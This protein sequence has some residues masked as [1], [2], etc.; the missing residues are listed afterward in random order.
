MN[1]KKRPNILF[2]VIDALRED[3]I[4]SEN[5]TTKT[6]TI[7]KL[8]NNGVYFSQAISTSDVTGTGIGCFFSGVYPFESGITESKIDSTLFTLINILKKNGYNMCG[9]G[10]NFKFFR[11]LS[12]F[13]D[14]SYYYDYQQWREIDTILGK[15]GNDIIDHLESIQKEP[16]F[17]YLH[18]MD[19]HGMGK[20][21]KIPSKFD[22][23]NFGKTKYDRMISCIDFW[24]K[25]LLKQIDLDNTIIIITADHGEYVSS[26]IDDPMGIPNVYKFL[27][28]MKKV[29]PILE[30]IGNQMFRILLKTNAN[31][32]RSI[33][34][35]QFDSKEMRDILTRGN[36]D[37]LFDD[38][39]KIPLIFSGNKIKSSKKITNL[40]RQIDVLPT[41]L[42][43]LGIKYSEKIQGRSLIPILNGEELEEIPVYIE[44]G[45][46]E[47]DNVGNTIGIR[48]SKYKYLRNRHNEKTDVRLFDIVDDPLELK[49]I[50]KIKLDMVEK[51]ERTLKE[52]MRNKTIFQKKE[53]TDEDKMIQD[54]LKKMGYL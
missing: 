41:I 38:V 24:L 30:P 14:D 19:I 45:N 16:W 26:K 32:K 22:N 10:P 33:L 7:D 23:D 2:L 20:L 40:V 34:S 25:D 12:N 5:R 43:I 27:R 39:L 37:E 53:L 4:S 15:S 51:L 47:H 6:P 13:L 3:R 8:R 50:S 35:I 21:I 48:T 44:T 31:L 52:I 29:I 46:A 54:E 11:N 49:N 42:E 18:L 17:Y 9:S 1:E 36:T 28:K